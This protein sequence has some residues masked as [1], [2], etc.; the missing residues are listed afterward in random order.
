MKITDENRSSSVGTL[1]NGVADRLRYEILGGVIVP[2]AKLRADDLKVKYEVSLTPIREALMQLTAEGLVIAERQ[3]GF[4]AAPVSLQNLH[5][6]TELR[7][8]LETLALRLSIAAGDLEWEANIAAAQHRLDRL[9][10]RRETK[11]PI[12]NE[13]WEYWHR[14]FHL[15]LIAACG[16]PL[17]ISF[18]K[19]VH[20]LCDRYRR[21]YLPIIRPVD[22]VKDHNGI[23][24]AARKRDGVLAVK[25]LTAH[26][27]RTES[28]IAA[29]VNT[30]PKESP[31]AQPQ[32]NR[33]ATRT[34][35]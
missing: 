32:S 25:L 26:I 29:G 5:E 4:R 13:E 14:Q 15:A 10:P 24:D 18:C 21:I 16:M 8:A 1:V 34:K 35:Q 27:R 11:R 6:V 28:V 19:T 20:D 30:I 3:R 2:G 31:A 7:I 22:R 9:T 12:I 17:L 33:P 23:A